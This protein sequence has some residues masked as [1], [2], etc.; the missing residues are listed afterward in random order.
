MKI[1]KNSYRIVQ[2][3]NRLVV[4]YRPWYKFKW[5]NIGSER[6][7]KEVITGIGKD[8]SF[9]VVKTQEAFNHAFNISLEMIASH[10]ESLRKQKKKPCV[11]HQE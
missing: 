7:D 1:F 9:Q 3:P 11:I 2:K 8:R 4:E 6:I 10:K 5:V